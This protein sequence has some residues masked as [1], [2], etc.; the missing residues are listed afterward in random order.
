MRMAV[1][2]LTHESAGVCPLFLLDDV[3]SELDVNRNRQLMERLRA[4]NAQV[5]VTTTSLDNLKLTRDSYA[6]F[7]VKNGVV[8]SDA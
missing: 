8:E 7:L 4:L 3:S 6:P 2:E 1:M 5:L